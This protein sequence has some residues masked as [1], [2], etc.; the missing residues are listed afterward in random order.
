[1][2]EFLRV[3]QNLM[4]LMI[5]IISISV[6]MV[7]LNFLNFFREWIFGVKTYLSSE[8]S[9][10]FAV[11]S[12][13]SIVIL[14]R[15]HSN[16]YYNSIGKSMNSSLAFNLNTQSVLILLELLITSRLFFIYL[17]KKGQSF[18]PKLIN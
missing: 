15:I 6:L 4:V 3:K 10:V 8:D 1:M 14:L 17:P 5:A 7:L 9:W 11:Q 13:V 2:N 18:A 12:I 16:I